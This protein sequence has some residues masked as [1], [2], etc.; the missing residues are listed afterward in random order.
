MKGSPVYFDLSAAPGRTAYNLLIGLVAPRPIAWVTSLDAEGRLNAAPFSAYNYVSID[1]P[2]LALG[3]ARA[4]E[5]ESGEKDTYLNIRATGE[6]VVNVVD[7][8]LVEAMNV[9]AVDFPRGVDEI[10]QAGLSAAPSTRIR[11]PRIA[12][13]PA[14]MECRVHT[15]LSLGNSNVVLGRVEAVHVRDALVDTAG[16]YIRAEELHAVGRMN[17]LGAY[18]RTRGAFFQVPRL[19]YRAWLRERGGS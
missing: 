6:F 3:V 11:P 9:C 15:I 5:R 8:A 10:A 2:V 12:Q 7:D 17:G 14:A 16:P 1:P 18:V 19:D 13:A 4:P